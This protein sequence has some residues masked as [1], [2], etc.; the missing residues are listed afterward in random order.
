MYAAVQRL[1]RD[2]VKASQPYIVGQLESDMVRGV[3]ILR[4]WDVDWVRNVHQWHR[5]PLA[6]LWRPVFGGMGYT[7]IVFAGL[8][9]QGAPPRRR[10]LAQ[11]WSC[12]IIDPQRARRYFDGPPTGEVPRSP[13]MAASPPSD[14]EHPFG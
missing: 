7:H 9:S 13:S 11:R 1:Y 4:L 6:K 12:E 14:P 8:E 10:W 5:P 3:P 2:G